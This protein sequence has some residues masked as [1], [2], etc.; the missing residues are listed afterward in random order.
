[1]SK[2]AA[3][4]RN[5]WLRLTTAS[6]QCLRLS[7]LLVSICHVAEPGPV[8][9]VLASERGDWSY[10]DMSCVCVCYVACSSHQLVLPAQ[11]CLVC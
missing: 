6:A 10:V 3:A 11:Y 9:H 4:R 2:G 5:F 1:M 7:E 8:K